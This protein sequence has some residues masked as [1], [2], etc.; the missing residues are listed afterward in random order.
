MIYPIV[1]SISY[2]LISYIL[3]LNKLSITHLY[4]TNKTYNKTLKIIGAIYNMIMAMFSLV[5]FVLLSRSVIHEYGDDFKSS[6][7]VEQSCN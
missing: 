1:S 2:I 4:K 7:L 5:T 6:C 3:K